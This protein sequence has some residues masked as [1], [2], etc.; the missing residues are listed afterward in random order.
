MTACGARSHE[1][2][3][4]VEAAQ[5][6]VDEV[7]GCGVTT[8]AYGVSRGDGLFYPSE[9][10]SSFGGAATAFDQVSYWRVAQNMASLLAAGHDPLQ[11]LIDRAHHHGMEFVA[12]LRMGGFD[13]LLEAVSRVVFTPQTPWQTARPSNHRRVSSPL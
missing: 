9:V 8:F 11:L 3:M 13:G 2:P 1:P 12:S 4:S 6:A 10:G 5:S 7:A